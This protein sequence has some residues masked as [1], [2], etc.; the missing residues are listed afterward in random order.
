MVKLL[1]L[2]KDLKAIPQEEATTHKDDR[3]ELFSTAIALLVMAILLGAI[4]SATTFTP[5]A[6]K[7][8]A[9]AKEVRK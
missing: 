1:R 6:E 2:P 3:K 5:P 4:V 8:T 7:V 9:V